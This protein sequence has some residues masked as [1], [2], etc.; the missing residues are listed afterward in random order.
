M[1]GIPRPTPL[2]F[3]FSLLGVPVR[4]SAWFW[5]IAAFV[6]WSLVRHTVPD[7]AGGGTLA[8]HLLIAGVCVFGSILLHEMAHALFARLYGMRWAV[9]LLG[10]GGLAYGPRGARVKWWQDVVIALAGPVA[11]LLFAGALI[12][13]AFAANRLAGPIRVDS[14]LAGTAA[15]ALLFVNLAWPVLN[16][17]PIF[18]LDGGQVL[19]AVLGRFLRRGGDLWTARVGLFVAAVCGALALVKLN[20]P[21]LGVLFG[22]LAV[23][24]YQAMSGPPVRR[25]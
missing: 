12:A 3:E 5:L 23:R 15:E 9:I 14:A 19:R 6:G 10:T 16:L 11:Q 4:V 2:D 18:P 22:L 13:G 17:L 24:N 7:G 25:R 21:F 8:A 20:S 1:F